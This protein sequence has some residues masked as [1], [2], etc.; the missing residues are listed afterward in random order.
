[1]LLIAGGYQYIF[2]SLKNESLAAD[3]DI[4]LDAESPEAAL[5]WDSYRAVKERLLSGGLFASVLAEAEING[6]V[7]T[8]E[9]SVPCSGVA[10][11]G[12]TILDGSIVLESVFEGDVLENPVPASIGVSLARTLGV[13]PGTLL[14]GFIAD[15]GLTL[16]IAELVQTESALKDR[17]YIALPLETLLRRGADITIKNLRIRL[18]KSLSAPSLNRDGDSPDYAAALALIR[19]IPELAPFTLYSLK[20]GNTATNKIVGVY[21][22]N[23]RVIEAVIM[24]SL[25]LAFLN[26]LSLSIYERRQEFGT[27]RA[28][29]TPV[30]HIRFLLITETL[31]IAAAAWIAG[32]LISTALGFLV[33]AAGGAVFPPP[34]GRSAVLRG[35]IRLSAAKTLT[36]G[37]PLATGALGGVLMSTLFF[38]KT[39]IVKQL[40]CLILLLFIHS[41]PGFAQNTVPDGEALLRRVDAYR[42]FAPA[43]FSFDFTVSEG[44]SRSLMR[45]SLDNTDQNNS[46]AQYREP[47]R[48]R[49]RLVLCRG[50]SFFIYEPGMTAPIRI[51]PREML[52]GQA[53]AGDITRISFSGSYSLE[54]TEERGEALLLRLKALNGRDATYDFIDLTVNKADYRPINA[55]CKGASG[56]VIKTIDYERF[57]TIGG[58]ELLTGFTI[59]D[60]AS[61]KTSIV[62]LSNFSAETLPSSSFTVEGIRFVR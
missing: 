10:L 51:T 22:T 31:L 53:A 2:D 59:T 52:F 40:Y 33:N 20:E 11:E 37:L 55:Q 47:A 9:R 50:N 39:G 35:G 1:M 57:E 5:A 3:G 32:V 23:Y 16:E 30:F 61:K 56:R 12:N 28:M 18:K 42:Q 49:R 21:R 13:S 29:G 15:C 26:V 46:I 45:V 62:V 27:L 41:L 6:L 24:I 19:D 38:G 36:A 8:A 43:G 7:G 60:G 14:S 44:T 58:R 4:R 25:C 17:F 34:P 48:Y 54:V